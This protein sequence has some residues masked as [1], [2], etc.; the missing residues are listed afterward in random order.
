MNTLIKDIVRDKHIVEVLKSNGLRYV[1]QL[2]VMHKHTL[3][4]YPFIGQQTIDTID[5][6]LFKNGYTSIGSRQAHELPAVV[7]KHM[8]KVAAQREA[9]EAAAE[10]DE[11]DFGYF[12]DC[13]DNSLA[14]DY[15]L[16]DL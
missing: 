4:Q 12:E 2:L 8:A 13:V 11:D 14:D 3:G 15:D 9:A 7:L 1:G 5:A 10:E 16:D 6:A